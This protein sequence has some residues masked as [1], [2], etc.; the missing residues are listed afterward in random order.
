MYHILHMNAHRFRNVDRDHIPIFWDILRMQ[1][2]ILRKFWD[3]LLHT[4]S[5]YAEILKIAI[6]K[7]NHLIYLSGHRMCL[8]CANHKKTLAG[9]SKH[10]YMMQPQRWDCFSD[11]SVLELYRDVYVLKEVDIHV[12]YTYV[13]A[14]HEKKFW[15]VFCRL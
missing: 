10:N 14:L 9:R 8:V 12:K 13:I 6:F 4:T 15:E 7:Q 3:F 5:T 2:Y 11:E 1:D